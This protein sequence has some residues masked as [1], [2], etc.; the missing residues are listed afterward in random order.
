MKKKEAGRKSKRRRFTAAVTRGP[1]MERARTCDITITE[2]E[3]DVAL[4][5]TE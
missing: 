1:V 4:D 3:N 5:H 2:E